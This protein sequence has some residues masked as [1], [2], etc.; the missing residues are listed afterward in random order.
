[1]SRAPAHAA[2]LRLTERFAFV[3]M[4]MVMAAFVVGLSVL[5]VKTGARV[6]TD[7][8]VVAGSARTE[9]TGQGGVQ[10]VGTG[11]QAA[12][13][14][15]GAWSARPSAV[16][17]ARLGKALRTALGTRAG[18]LSVGVVNTATGAEALYRP[19]KRY[20]AGGITEAD[21]LAALLY[22]HQQ[23]RTPIGSNHAALA[24]KMIETGNRTAAASLWQAI[25]RGA[26]LA[27]ANQALGLRHTV[28]GAADD[29]G[30]T[31]TTAADQLR[32]LTDLATARPALNSAGRA[33]E[34]G[35]MARSAAARRWGALAAVS[36]GTSYVVNDRRQADSRRFVI[37]CVAIIDQA[38]HE[39]LVV[40]LSRNWHTQEAGISAVH[41]AAAAAV[42]AMLRSP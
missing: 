16:L 23:S 37:N 14:S 3:M 20:R 40:V 25:G 18:H 13:A 38:G 39:L 5:A 10:G 27:A 28:P 34:R 35:L 36:T 32:L 42:S 4:F 24:A 17:N 22:Q 30:L 19:D 6:G 29:W 8:P 26:G 7:L 9:Q 15:A 31:R 21:I 11:K 2:S 12:G 1:V 33:Y 41:A